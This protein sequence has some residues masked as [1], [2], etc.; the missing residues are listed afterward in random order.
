MTLHHTRHHQA[1][2]NNLNAALSN[3]STAIKEGDIADQIALQVSIKFNGGGHINHSLF[4][5]NLAPANSTDATDP[6][7]KAPT[8]LKDVKAAYGS[9][10]GLTTAFSAALM[11]LQGSG[12]GWLVKVN[13]PSGGLRI[14][15]TANQDPVVGGEVPIIGVDMWEHAYY[16]QVR[17]RL[18]SPP[19]AL[20]RN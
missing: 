10:A 3:Y 13:G 19:R 17:F 7:G 11:A 9:L 15:T 4:W 14:V 12:W 6:E 18:S 2:V 1:Y 20:G 16:L 8:L 5:K